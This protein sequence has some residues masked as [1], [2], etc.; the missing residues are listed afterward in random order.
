[1]G[2][3]HTRSG[4]GHCFPLGLPSREVVSVADFPERSAVVHKHLNY[5]H[6][7]QFFDRRTFEVAACPTSVHEEEGLEDEDED[8]D[9][10][11]QRA[12]ARVERVRA[13]KAAEEKAARAAAAREKAAQEAR[14]RARRAQQQEEEVSERRRLLAAAATARSQRRTSP[15]E[16][17]VLPQRPVVEILKKSKG[18]GKAKAQPVDEDPDDGDDGDNDDDEKEPCERCDLPGNTTTHCEGAKGFQGGVMSCPDRNQT[19]PS[20]SPHVLTF[21]TLLPPPQDIP[22][23]YNSYYAISYGPALL[24]NLP[25]PPGNP[26]KGHHL[27]VPATTRSFPS[28]VTVPVA[29]FELQPA[30]STLQHKPSYTNPYHKTHS[31]PGLHRRRVVDSDEEEEREIEGEMEKDREEVEEGEEEAPAPNRAKAATSEKGKEKEV[32]E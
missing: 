26:L 30:P 24:P 16:V 11:I 28:S 29:P 32:V 23:A 20:T 10:I 2:G 31:D 17:S 18:K 9:E 1:M 19:N 3:S 5:H 6:H 22:E 15:S 14:E 7:D 27:I 8:E 4:H 13:R 21:P 25:G 12:Q